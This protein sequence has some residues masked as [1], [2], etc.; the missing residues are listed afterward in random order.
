M[1]VIA[2]P[3]K[4]AQR[5]L[6]RLRRLGKLDPDRRPRRKDHVL[7]IP[8]RAAA[9]LAYPVVRARL[10]CAKRRPR[11]LREAAVKVLSAAER[12]ALKAAYDRV[13]DLA[14]L[15][16]DGSLAKKAKMLARMLLATHPAIKT[17]LK[18]G[19]H[20]GRYR[21]QR[22]MWLAGRNIRLTTHVESGVRLTVDVERVY[23]SPRLSGE[24][25]RIA[26]LVK[27]GEAVL[28]M[29]SGAAPYPCIIAKHAQAARIVGV[30]HNP[31]GHRLGLRNIAR[32]KLAHVELHCGDVRSV[33]PALSAA[34]DRIIMPLPQGAETF[35]ETALAAAKPRAV[36]HIYQFCKE[37]AIAAQGADLCRAIRALGWAARVERAVRC[38]QQGPRQHRVCFDID[39]RK[40]GSPR[41]S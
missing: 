29:F 16:V 1:P 11:S 40:P 41:K 28:V 39:V 9:G 22:L 19:R 34:F 8:V 17:V 33:V 38:G 5:V 27:P 3:L 10:P 13:G 6:D 35:L 21:T 23:F 26:R 36:L 12:A 37:D 2:V 14:I 25:L 18:K 30:E 24:R 7:L 20:T 32:N 31:I 4:E 15:E